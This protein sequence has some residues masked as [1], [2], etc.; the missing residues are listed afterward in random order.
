MWRGGDTVDI[1][2]SSKGVDG[3]AYVVEDENSYTGVQPAGAKA[4]RIGP[5]PNVMVRLIL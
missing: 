1:R 3:G 4:I 5:L 2:I